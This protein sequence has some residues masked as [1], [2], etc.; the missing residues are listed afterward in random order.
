MIYD[1]CVVKIYVVPL[2]G[3]L[4]EYF[5][6]SCAGYSSN[7]RWISS[8]TKLEN[9]NLECMPADWQEQFIQE[10]ENSFI[11]WLLFHI[12]NIG[13]NGRSQLFFL[14][15]TAHYYGLS[16]EGIRTLS[17]YG[18]GVTL[19]MFDSLRQI[20]EIKAVALTR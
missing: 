1:G 14:T 9:L 8:T 18:Y 5:M 10:N 17:R 4:F 12:G 3:W 6:Y 16:R 13:S 19:D 20:Q 15:F 2:G 7:K 11:G